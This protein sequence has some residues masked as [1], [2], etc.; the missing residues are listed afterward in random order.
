[1]KLSSLNLDPS[2]FTLS[3]GH[4]YYLSAYPDPILEI[5]PVLTPSGR[6][7]PI[8]LPLNYKQSGRRP[9]EALW[10]ARL[11]DP[12]PGPL[13]KFRIRL[14]N[15]RYDPPAPGE[16]YHTALR[17]VWLQGQQLFDYRPAPAV[18]ASQVVK[19]P[20]FAGGLSAR[21]LYVYLPRGYKEH[22]DRHYPVLYMHDGQNVFEAFA[23][24]SYVGSWKADETADALIDAGRM[25]ECLI[26]GV[27]HGEATRRI[28]Y[29]PPYISRP[30]ELLIDAPAKLRKKTR[31]REPY[32]PAQMLS[33][34]ADQTF[35]YYQDDVAAYI[36]AH[37][38]ALAGREHTAVCGSSMGGIF[39][40]YIAWEHP[41]FARHYAAL[42]PALVM[43]TGFRN[44][45]GVLERLQAGPRRDVRIWLDSGTQDSPGVGD[46]D[47]VETQA[48]RD[49]LLALGYEPGKDFRYYLDEGAIHQEAAWAN[50][51]P[52]VFSF[53]F[54]PTEK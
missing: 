39:S 4:F 8:R 14:S 33:G 24:N 38:R 46:D 41:E 7:R 29:T 45:Q 13:W 2:G 36:R 23:A 6:A 3:P 27:S 9:D 30:A 50:R 48:A 17:T 52:E 40:L 37:Y 31:R 25:R 28:E 42:S 47:K 16:F 5:Q 53:L 15:R 1:M 20:A 11:P 43:T 34:Q 54:P 21:A 35:V 22:P 51:L 26:V 49:A 10:A 44:E 12:L 18:T 32:A 19:I